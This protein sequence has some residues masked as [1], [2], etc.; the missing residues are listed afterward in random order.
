MCCHH[1]EAAVNKAMYC[2]N[3]MW[4]VLEDMSPVSIFPTDSGITMYGR[5]Q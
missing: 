2:E 5:L 1:R 3:D 4:A